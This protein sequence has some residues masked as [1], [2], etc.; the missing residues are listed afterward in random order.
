MTVTVYMNETIGTA[1]GV[2]IRRICVRDFRIH[3]YGTAVSDGPLETTLYKS[4]SKQIVREILRKA[5]GG[6]QP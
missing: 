5:G 1:A 6:I 2:L 3:E 4:V